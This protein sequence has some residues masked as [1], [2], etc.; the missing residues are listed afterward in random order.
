M[1]ISFL[2]IGIN[3]AAKIVL[4]PRFGLPGL[5]LAT[6]LGAWIN[7]MLLVIVAQRR[8]LIDLDENFH[9]A[10]ALASLAAAAMAWT[11][12]LAQPSAL[13]YLAGVTRFR[14]EAG[15]A[16]VGGL[17]LTVYALAVII[18]ARVIGLSLRRL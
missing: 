10:M 17:G 5:A 3:V 16:L 11:M 14:D 4:A 15:L 8:G 18:G 7:L 12:L 6:A 9:A 2:A 13:A 1:L